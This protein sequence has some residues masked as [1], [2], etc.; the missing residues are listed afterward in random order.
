VFGVDGEREIL[1]GVEGL[2]FFAL[3]NINSS[4]PGLCLEARSK[5]K[6]RCRQDLTLLKELLMEQLEGLQ[7]SQV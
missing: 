2:R 6:F 7:V 4:S 3:S 1:E 5:I